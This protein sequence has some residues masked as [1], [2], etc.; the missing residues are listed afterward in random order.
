M[1]CIGCRL[2]IDDRNVFCINCGNL[3]RQEKNNSKTYFI[4]SVH[5]KDYIDYRKEFNYI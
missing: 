4:L 5:L 2:R 3:L 1:Y